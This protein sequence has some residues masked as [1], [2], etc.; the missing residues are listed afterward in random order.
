MLRRFRRPTDRTRAQDILALWMAG[1]GDLDAGAAEAAGVMG[2]PAL[3]VGV[4]V[5]IPC[6]RAAPPPP[7]TACTPVAPVACFTPIT[8][9]ILACLF[10]SC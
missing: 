3:S 10:V 2:K 7:D 9:T 5:T 4:F 1:V 8:I 6:A